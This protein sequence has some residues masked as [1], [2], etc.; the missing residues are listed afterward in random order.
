[1]TDRL[2]RIEAIL[3]RLAAQQ[4]VT[5]AQVDQNARVMESSTQL[6][7]SNARAIEANSNE[8]AEGFAQ[9][10]RE[11]QA[12]LEDVTAMILSSIQDT[13]R[14]MRETD[15]RFNTLLAEARADR[16]RNEQEHQAFRAAIQELL[17]D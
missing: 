1:M 2:D 11:L 3:D 8:I 13:D 14:Q 10:G 9:M 7:A 4:A 16:Q 17:N 5:Q 6:I 12:N 15:E